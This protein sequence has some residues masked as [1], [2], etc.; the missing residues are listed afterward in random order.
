MHL[1]NK[2]P[3]GKSSQNINDNHKKKKKKHWLKLHSSSKFRGN[4]HYSLTESLDTLDSEDLYPELLP[5]ESEFSLSA[6]GPPSS[7]IATSSSWPRE[8]ARDSRLP[9]RPLAPLLGGFLEEGERGGWGWLG[10]GGEV[11]GLPFV[12]LL[13]L[14]A[15]LLVRTGR[16]QIIAFKET[17]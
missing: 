16:N 2:N 14:L 9:T 13:L 4:Q 10:V 17:E 11:R 3:E 12:R 6:A 8:G 7:P 1:Q 15:S 5:P